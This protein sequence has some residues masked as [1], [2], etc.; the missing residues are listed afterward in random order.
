[1]EPYRTINKKKKKMF[2][3][4]NRLIE[5]KKPDHIMWNSL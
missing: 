2:Y 1:M 3:G 5:L 4:I